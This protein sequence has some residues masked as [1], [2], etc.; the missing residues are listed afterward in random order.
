MGFLQTYGPE[1]PI[2]QK[3]YAFRNALCPHA[4]KKLKVTV[5]AYSRNQRLTEQI[6]EL[7]R[8]TEHALW[9]LKG[10]Y[11]RLT[12]DHEI[13]KLVTL[14]LRHEFGEIS[15]IVVKNSKFILPEEIDTF[16]APYITKS[17]E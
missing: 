9:E 1:R 6:T 15:P 4:D 2:E 12:I 10:H 14:F 8:Y 17:D 16:P 7:V 3:Y 13:A 5:R 11:D